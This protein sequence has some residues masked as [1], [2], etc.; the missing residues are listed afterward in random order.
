M[1]RP[2]PTPNEILESMRKPDPELIEKYPHADFNAAV[3]EA[4]RTESIRRGGIPVGAHISAYQ[5]FAGSVKYVTEQ[6]MAQQEK[7]YLDKH[8]RRIQMEMQWKGRR[9]ALRKAKENVNLLGLG[10][11]NKSKEEEKNKNLLV[12]PTRE[13]ELGGLFNSPANGA[14]VRAGG[15]AVRAGGA[16]EAE[17]GRRRKRKTRKGKKRSYRK[18]TRR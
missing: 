5:G 18:K 4:E 9:E 7:E 6:L 12:F 17:G 1:S 11:I 16:A 8:R 2:P 10:N 3:R 14:A 13:E 15:A